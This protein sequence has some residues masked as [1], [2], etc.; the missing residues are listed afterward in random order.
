MSLQALQ[1]CPQASVWWGALY[2]Y[3]EVQVLLV[4]KTHELCEKKYTTIQYNNNSITISLVTFFQCETK[5]SDKTNAKKKIQKTHKNKTFHL[6]L[7]QACY[8]TKGYKAWRWS[9]HHSPPL[10]STGCEAVSSH[11]PE[12]CHVPPV[13]TEIIACKIN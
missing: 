8:L 4:L 9:T 11:V 3:E 7:H 10:E 2:A 6:S 12:G 13:K 1:L 5:R